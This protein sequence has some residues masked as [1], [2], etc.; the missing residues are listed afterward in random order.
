[1]ADPVGVPG[2]P[3]PQIEPPRRWRI[4]LVWVIPLVIALIGVSLVA[5]A[6][7]QRGPTITVTFTS[8][9]GIVPGQTKVKYKDVDVGEVRS[10][11][12]SEDRSRVV[13]T[14]ELTKEARP[15]A[16]EDS[17][18]WVVRPRLAASGITGLGTLL[19]GSYIGVDAGRSDQRRTD[20]VGIEQP[21]AVASDVP[22]RRFRLRADDIGSLDVGSPVYFR[23]L[24]VGHVENYALDPDGR[25]VN[26][27]VF[28]NSP[29]DNFVTGDTRFW[30]ASG[31]EV[32]LDAGG[33]RLDTQSL[34]TIL[35][36]GIAFETP[37]GAAKAT[38]A[39]AGEEFALAADRDEAMK[40]PEGQPVAVLLHFRQS[41][42]GLS[43]GAPVDF[44][45]VEIGRVRSVDLAYDPKSGEFLAPVQ[46]DIFPDR[47]LSLG[48]VPPGSDARAIR[49]SRLADLVRRGLRAQLRTGSLLT[50]QLY[51]SF[52]FFPDAT[53]VAFNP[54]A[55]P[56]EMPTVPSDIEELQRQAQ[57]ILSKLD[58]VP[59]DTL[60]Q[61]IHKAL[62]DLDGSLKRLDAA[63]ERTNSETLP[64]VR[65]TLRGAKQTLDAVQATL[66]PDSPLQ[67]DTRQTLQDFAA[68]ARSLKA[69]SDSL[70]RHPESILRGRRGTD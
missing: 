14:I 11:V 24:P 6:I 30:H 49:R 39:T 59:F 65:D 20:F 61:D 29:Y 55:Q 58:K 5:Q 43:L 53:A 26:L 32:R 67:Q 63:A 15:F 10:V 8:A 33:L 69:L 47:L 56:L 46:V 64:E 48:P 7:L 45:G 28:V 60:S 4:S 13:V 44:R 1:M 54:A 17:R 70:E 34:A 50:G 51:V 2:L 41:V 18:F 31:I 42:R 3:E 16:V 68:L 62:V 25:H 40:T 27:G 9:E 36:G 22:G 57:S 52:D 38:L 35:L 23:R 21:P 12:L 66:A 37:P 19:S